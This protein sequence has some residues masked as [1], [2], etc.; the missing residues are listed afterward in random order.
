ME[1]AAIVIL[2][3]NGKEMLQKFLPSVIRLSAFPVYVADNASTDGSVDFLKND[4]PDVRL[5]LLDRN[6]GFA[7]GYNKALQ[8]IRGEFEY[9]ILLNSDVEVTPSW[10]TK[11]ISWLISHPDVVALQPKILSF[12]NPGYFDH[13]G[14]GGGFLDELG[15][16]YCRG[17][18]FETLEK[19][20]GQYD[21]IIPVEWAS[22][23]CMAVKAEE[24]H[25]YGGFDV[26][27]FAHMEEI[28][29]CWRWRS[30]G[31]KIYYHGGVL[32]RHVGAA[33][34]SKSNP[35]KT[36]LN[37]RN[38]LLMLHNNLPEGEFVRVYGK[39]VLLDV[40]AAVTFVM[41]GKM[42]HA[43]AVAKAHRSFFTL[44][45]HK[46]DLAPKLTMGKSKKGVKSIVWEYYF[47]GI[48]KYSAL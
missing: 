2:N 46:S 41:Q 19:D 32:I 35:K 10:D 27:F 9:N 43:T 29:L 40:L 16:P 4:F 14:A 25:K 24:Y 3:Y 28:D 22:G 12:Q 37:F 45:S 20:N 39:R 8:K 11:L 18:L 23:A 36:F 44:K 38:S 33:T 47:K 5:L 7:D 42:P 15:Y 48:K 6:Y 21:D 34:L 17:R 1:R 26:R 30:H 31:K 13:A